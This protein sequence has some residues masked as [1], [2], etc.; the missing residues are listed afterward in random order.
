MGDWFV[1]LVPEVESIVYDVD[2]SVLE[3]CNG[4]NLL[5]CLCVYCEKLLEGPIM[6]RKCEHCCCRD[7]FLQ[8]NI[9]KPMIETKCPLCTMPVTSELDLMA[10]R[11]V[12]TIINNLNV[13][14]SEGLFIS[15]S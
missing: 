9:K 3:M 4:Q 11:T 10:S 7:C 8:N 2:L 13:P 6:F 1:K 14:C 5:Q 12:Q 15:F